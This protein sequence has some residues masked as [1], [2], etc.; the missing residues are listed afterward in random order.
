MSYEYKRHGQTHIVLYTVV[1]QWVKENLDKNEERRRK[2]GHPSM[3]RTVSI[4]WLSAYVARKMDIKRNERH[5]KFHHFV[6]YALREL[7]TS[8]GYEDLNNDE[9]TPLERIYVVTGRKSVAK[10]RS[11]PLL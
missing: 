4:K 11:V 1:E 3:P 2:G 10:N 6:D 5:S 8:E 9:V 7:T